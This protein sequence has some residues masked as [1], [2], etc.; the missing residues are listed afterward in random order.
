MQR[1]SKGAPE[2]VEDEGKDGFEQRKNTPARGQRRRQKSGC[3]GVRRGLGHS[4]A[5]SAS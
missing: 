5:S 4:A 2:N 3:H 1:V